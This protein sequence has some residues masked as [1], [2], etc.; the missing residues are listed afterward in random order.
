MPESCL[1][2]ACI[3]SIRHI[4]AFLTLGTPD[5]TLALVSHF[6]QQNHQKAQKCENMALNSPQKG[7][8]F[9]VRELKQEGREV[10]CSVSAGNMHV[11]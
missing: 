3:F 8:L 6:K 9:T 4:T 7:H 10:P 2:N 5:N 11:H 1:S